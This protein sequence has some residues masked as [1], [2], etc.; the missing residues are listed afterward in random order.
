MANNNYK[1]IFVSEFYEKY[2]YKSKLR[3]RDNG[4]IPERE[5]IQHGNN[6]QNKLKKIW[7]DERVRE[8]NRKAITINTKKGTYLEF[9]SSPNY[10]LT[11]KSLESKREG[12]RLLNV[13]TDV[14]DNGEMINKATVFIPKGKEQ[15]FIKKVKDYTDGKKRKN[16]KQ[17]ANTKL[18][19]SINDIK[20]ALLDSFWIGNKEWM[21]KDELVWCEIWLSSDSEE[22]EKEFRELASNLNIEVKPEKLYF[23][24]RTVL[25]CKVNKVMLEQLIDNSD[26]IAEIRRATIAANFF[27]ELENSEQSDWVDDI[28]Q[29]MSVNENSEVV[30]SILDTGINNGHS[31]ISSVLNDKDC[32]SHVDQWGT[33]DH[34]GHGTKMAG[35]CIF[36]ELEEA[37]ANNNKLEINHN[38]ESYKILPPNGNNEPELY[39]SITSQS[40]S[41]LL[42]D[43]PNRKRVI[44]MAITSPEYDTGD[45]SPTSWSAA[46]DEITSGYIDDKQKLFIVSSG[47]IVEQSDYR[48]YPTSN[49]MFTVQNPGQSWNAITVGAYT[50]KFN[51]NSVAKKGQLSPYS[52]TSNLW[53]SKWPIKPEVLFEGGNLIKDI[54]G[55]WTVEDLSVLTT[56]HEPNKNQFTTIWG[57]SSAT[58]KASYMAAK[59]L[60][61]YPN[62]WPE[63]IR[64]LIIHSAE[65]SKEMKEQFL[66]GN[67][68]INYKKLLRCCGYGIPNLNRAIKCANNSVNL[69]IESELQPF[70]RVKS[71]I[72]TKDMNIHELPWPKEVLEELFDTTVELRITL[73]YFIEPGPGE[74]GWKDR[75]KY[76]SCS[77]R[78]DVNGLD[79][80]NTFISRISDAIANNDENIRNS[81]GG[82]DWI[83]G[84]NNRNVGSIHSDIWRG[85]AAEL[86]TCNIVSVYPVS[87]WWKERKY[88]E[89]WNKKIR[90]SL[91]VSIS[92]PETEVDLY[93]PIITKIENEIKNKSKVSIKV[94]K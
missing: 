2:K 12:I 37:L 76:P 14:N 29:R 88:L 70:D 36:G 17:P 64:G 72:K 47:N 94:H 92:T 69:I 5:R 61:E 26:F 6:I 93:T 23:P 39:G 63:T 45:G 89:R 7:N 25:C 27:T 19:A 87:G 42:I 85:S 71:D 8:E 77:L 79:D 15:Y 81:S 67:K 58:A 48:N 50:D 3:P 91:I 33:Y 62:A 41:N 54:Y 57:T 53:D 28:L 20:L 44:C 55:C 90:Y 21:P 24:E 49:E 74:I 11:S 65:W 43:N 1:N 18:I 31:L 13:R 35:V 22:D 30:I 51:D 59:L 66:C 78:F 9:Q 60:G 82:I 34:E 32:Y 83:L 16:S 40:V 38:L 84:K 80:K 46:I 52:S 4:E 10:E 73:S 56:N 75:Y 86:A 68:K